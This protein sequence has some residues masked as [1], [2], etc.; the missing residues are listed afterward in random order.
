MKNA[1]ILLLF[2]VL[3]ASVSYAQEPAKYNFGS[4]QGEEN[5]TV[6]PGEEFELVLYFYNVFGNRTTH[7][8]LFVEKLPPNWEIKISPE[9]SNETYEVSGILT[10]ISENLFVEPDEIVDEVPVEKGGFTYLPAP[11]VGGFIPAKAVTIKVKVPENEQL[12]ETFELKINS[13]AEWLGQG[14]TTAFN[15]TREF[16]YNIAIVSENFYEKKVEEPKNTENNIEVESVV[17]PTGL[18]GLISSNFV[19]TLLVILV[20]LAAVIIVIQLVIMRK[21]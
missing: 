21:R 9:R 12:G 19:T 5:L 2:L 18:F 6:S 13:V 17:A 8:S 3:F 15:Q 7:I 20:G 4:S 16:S 10:E 1:F 14:G 11:N